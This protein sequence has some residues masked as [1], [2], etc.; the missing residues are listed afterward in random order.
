[1]SL[2]KYNYSRLLYHNFYSPKHILLIYLSALLLFYFYLLPLFII[3]PI[4]PPSTPPPKPLLPPLSN[5]SLLFISPLSYSTFSFY[6]PPKLHHLP[7]HH[8]ISSLLQP[9][10][11]FLSLLLT[12]FTPHFQTSKKCQ[13]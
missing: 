5:P 9:F 13:R 6:F 3:F 8:H 1:M 4:T 12:N 11:Y 2:I 10:S 7:L